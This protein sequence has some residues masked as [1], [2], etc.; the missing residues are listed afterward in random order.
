MTRPHQVLPLHRHEQIHLCFSEE[1]VSITGTWNMRIATPLGT[2]LVTLE[3]VEHNGA[4]SGVAKGASETTPLIDPVLQDNR[5]TWKQS[6]TKPMRLH[7][8]FDV[9]I[10]GDS[11]TGTSKAGLLPTSNVVGTRVSGT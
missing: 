4:V 6:I 8:V 9:T 3:L 10:E 5:L 2:Q 11:M 7:L 1:S